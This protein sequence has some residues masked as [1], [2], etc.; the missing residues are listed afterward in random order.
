MH[1]NAVLW[2]NQ[3][4]Q[5]WSDLRRGEA[6]CTVSK[7]L[8]WRLCSRQRSREN[9]DL[10]S[11]KEQGE[12]PKWLSRRGGLIKAGLSH[13]EQ[14]MS[15]EGETLSPYGHSWN[16]GSCSG[17]ETPS[18]GRTCLQRD[19]SQVGKSAEPMDKGVSGWSGEPDKPHT[20]NIWSVTIRFNTDTMRVITRLATQHKDDTASLEQYDTIWFSD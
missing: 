9:S 3:Q 11:Q 17:P 13:T 12:F 7:A 8:T 6:S 2:Q 4:S 10:K 18:A 1:I 20:L 15:R 19:M 16:R 5:P 14:Q